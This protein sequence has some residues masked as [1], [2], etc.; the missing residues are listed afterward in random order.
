MA[1]LANLLI[2]L[3]CTGE[4]KKLMSFTFKLAANLLLDLVLNCAKE[5]FYTVR[6]GTVW[7]GTVKYGTILYGTVY[8][9]VW[10]GIVWYGKMSC[11]VSCRM[12]RQHFIY[13]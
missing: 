4:K 9:I 2:T 13:P 6:Y 8:G 7:Y 12:R 11:V 10:Y 5:E 3:P 1:N